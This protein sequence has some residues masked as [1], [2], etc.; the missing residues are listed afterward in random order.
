[1]VIASD[2]FEGRETGEP[3]AEKA[4]AYIASHFESLGIAPFDGKTYYQDVPLVQSQIQGGT[5][6]VAGKSMVFLKSSCFIQE[7]EMVR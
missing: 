1:M 5:A 7:S 2:A 4:A 3:G 6:V